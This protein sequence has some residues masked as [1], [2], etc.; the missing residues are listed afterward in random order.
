LIAETTDG[1]VAL[2]PESGKILWQCDVPERLDF[3]VCGGPE[4]LC[5]AAAER[6]E[7]DQPRRPV[8]VWIDPAEG[9][10]LAETTLDLPGA[11]YPLVGPVAV[12]GGRTWL[13][14]ATGE[15]EPSRAVCGLD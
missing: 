10:T 5:C 11:Q 7:P 1:L 9:T 4:G 14:V 13:F 12:A 6:V 8:L 2:D 3:R 15:N